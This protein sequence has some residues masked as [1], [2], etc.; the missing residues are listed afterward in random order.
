MSKAPRTIM[1][2]ELENKCI[3]SPCIK[4]DV[5]IPFKPLSVRG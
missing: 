1:G 5:K 3:Q 2:T 4:G